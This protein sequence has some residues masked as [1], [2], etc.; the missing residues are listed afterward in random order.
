MNLC[1]SVGVCRGDGG[2]GGECNVR[3]CLSIRCTWSNLWEFYNEVNVA[4]IVT[5][6]YPNCCYCHTKGHETQ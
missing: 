5:G 6:E 3:F 2:V 4:L 1:V